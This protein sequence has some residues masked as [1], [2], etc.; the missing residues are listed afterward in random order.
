MLC[1]WSMLYKHI[2][3]RIYLYNRYTVSC[4]RHQYNWLSL[5]V[6]LNFD[7]DWWLN[8]LLVVVYTC[9]GVLII[10]FYTTVGRYSRYLLSYKWWILK[11]LAFKIRTPSRFQTSP[12]VNTQQYRFMKSTNI[13]LTRWFFFHLDLVYK[14]NKACLKVL[15]YI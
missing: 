2:Y 7:D 13:F 5:R 11:W 1:V 8:T 6:P 12:L 15:N 3:P 14:N 9:L 4:P 10:V